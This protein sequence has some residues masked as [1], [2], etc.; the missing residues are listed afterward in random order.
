M[1]EAFDPRLNF[2][3][4]RGLKT[5]N[6]GDPDAAKTWLAE[7]RQ[8]QSQL[9]EAIHASERQAPT[10]LLYLDRLAVMEQQLLT[11]IAWYRDDRE[12]ALDHAREA[13]RLEGE[14]P[15]AFGPPFVDLPA[16]EMLGGFLLA[17]GHAA[18]AAA[19]FELQLQRTRNKTHALAGLASAYQ[20]MG[21]ESDA[22]WAAGRHALNLASAEQQD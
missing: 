1:G 12:L 2:A 19:A 5:A 11:F 9:T 21:K 10:H 22:E 14:M 8:L 13:S 18:E 3:Y 17:D 7:F 4:Y 15:F 20:Q 6:A 16:A